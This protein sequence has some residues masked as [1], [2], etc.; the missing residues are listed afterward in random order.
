ML[1]VRMIAIETPK[2]D[3]SSPRDGDESMMKC[4]IVYLDC[5]FSMLT[6]FLNGR[7][8]IVCSSLMN[9]S[10][11]IHHQLRLHRYPQGYDA[12]AQDILQSARLIS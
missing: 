5:E 1:H 8:S 12:A 10:S 9:R 6:S 4:A 2:A 11:P 7:W 3:A